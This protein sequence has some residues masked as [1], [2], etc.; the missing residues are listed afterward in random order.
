MATWLEIPL[1]R[2]VVTVVIVRSR[3]WLR[4]FDRAWSRMICWRWV[5]V[6][7]VVRSLPILPTISPLPQ[8]YSVPNQR[9][10]IIS[11]I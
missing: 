7:F 8:G 2:A 5:S 11:D 1:C 9:A 4:V 3:S 10:C 6:F